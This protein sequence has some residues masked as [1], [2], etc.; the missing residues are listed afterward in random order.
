[1]L[2][3]FINSSLATTLAEIVTLPI[4][5]TKTNFQNG[6]YKNIRTTIS[7]IYNSRGIKGFYKASFPSVSGQVLSTAS[8]YT[9][10]RKLNEI[11]NSHWSMKYLNGILC[12]L[13]VSLI[14][15]PLDAIKVHMQMDTKELMKKFSL[16]FFYSGYKWSFIKTC[17]SGPLFFP[18]CDFCKEE[19]GSIFYGSM[20]ASII[21]TTIMHPVDYFK[22]RG[23]YGN[24]IIF[25]IKSWFRGLSLNLMRIVPHFIIVMTTIDYLNKK[26]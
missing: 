17:I 4:C 14:T 8:K 11:N 13:S 6:T 26:N 9:V 15:H 20:M 25:G 18:L 19:T 22:T 5:T 10:Y 23:L 3:D 2:S 24:D 16:K 21:A 7:S 12:G 1:M